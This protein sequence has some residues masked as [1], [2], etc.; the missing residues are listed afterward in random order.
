MSADKKLK[1][2]L[3]LGDYIKLLYSRVDE[4]LVMTRTLNALS[5]NR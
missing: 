3:V 2:H 4:N 1:M 5:G